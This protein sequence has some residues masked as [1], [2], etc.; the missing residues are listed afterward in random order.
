MVVDLT[1]FIILSTHHQM[2]ATRGCALWGLSEVSNAFHPFQ[3]LYSRD[4]ATWSE[5]PL[6]LSAAPSAKMLKEYKSHT[7]DGYFRPG[8]KQA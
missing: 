5:I 1:L 4:L 8:I 7:N 3:K 6:G 2:K